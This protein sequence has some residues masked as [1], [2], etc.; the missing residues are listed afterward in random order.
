ME[1]LVPQD[2]GVVHQD[3]D[4]AERL[5]R[6]GDDLVGIGRIADRDRR[7]DGL[8]AFGLDLVDDLLRG[9]GVAARAIERNPDVVDDDLGAFFRQHQRNG[10][11]DAAARAGD[12]GDF[13]LNNPWH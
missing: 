6:R 9:P 8:P 10:A 13:V 12:D 3:V 4:A 11:A 2:A 5:D 1:D 7:G